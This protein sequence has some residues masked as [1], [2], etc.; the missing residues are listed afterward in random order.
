MSD[1]WSRSLGPERAGRGFRT[2]ELRRSGAVLALGSDWP[3]AGFDPRE[4]MAW[5]RLR[6]RPGNRDAGGYGEHQRLSALE[7]L[8]GYTT[9]AALAVNDTAVAGRI[10]PGYRG[11]LTAFAADPVDCDADDLVDLPVLLT[12]VDGR[13]VHRA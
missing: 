10:M 11:D 1:P 4:C 7:A 9:Q 12:V 5:A 8:E 3:V 6:R 2:A 13:A